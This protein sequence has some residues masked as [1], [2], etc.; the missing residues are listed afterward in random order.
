MKSNILSII[1][2]LTLTILTAGSCKVLSGNRPESIQIIKATSQ[3]WNGGFKGSSRGVNFVIY[4]TSSTAIQPD[5]LWVNGTGFALSIDPKNSSDTLIFKGGYKTHPNAPITI[6]APLNTSGKGVMS[7]YLEKN[8]KFMP[9]EEF[10][11]LPT[12]N[13]P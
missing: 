1:S 5:S 8:K 10:T 11:V 13:Y 3:Q 12:L 7:Y 4:A 9:I 6:Q 2:L